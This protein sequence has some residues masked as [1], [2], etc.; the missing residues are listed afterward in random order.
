MLARIGTGRGQ[1]PVGAADLSEIR[2]QLLGDDAADV[3][4]NLFLVLRAPG[5]SGLDSF[6]AGPCLIWSSGAAG[7]CVPLHALR[8]ARGAASSALEP[9]V[10]AL[11]GRLPVDRT[12]CC[13]HHPPSKVLR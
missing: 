1:D 11:S 8:N 12:R 7:S 9:P 4:Q 5:P 6:L 10:V 2:A 13:Q 3:F